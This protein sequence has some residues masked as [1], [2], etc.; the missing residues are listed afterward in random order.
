MGGCMKVLLFLKIAIMVAW[1]TLLQNDLVIAW[2]LDFHLHKCVDGVPHEHMG[3][4]DAQW[5][6]HNSAESL[7]SFPVSRRIV[8]ETPF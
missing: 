1:V 6:Q 8:V 4:V 3:V 5:I 2:G 7:V